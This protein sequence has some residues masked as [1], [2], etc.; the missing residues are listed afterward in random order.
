MT[1]KDTRLITFANDD[2]R[3]PI[4]YRPGDVLMVQPKALE[5]SVHTAVEALGLKD[6]EMDAPFWLEASDES[7]PLPPSW[8]LSRE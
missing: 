8:I 3:Q 2:S 4:V 5:E 1:V 6:E 7:I